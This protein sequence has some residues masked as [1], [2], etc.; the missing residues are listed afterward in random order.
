[1][2]AFWDSWN[3][4][5]AANNADAAAGMQQAQGLAAMMQQVQKQQ[6][7]QRMRDMLADPSIPPEKKR[8]GLMGL[9]T[10]PGQVA[11]MFHQQATETATNDLRTAQLTTQQRLLEESQRK[12]VED[13][14]KAEE[15]KK[16]AAAQ[17]KLQGLLAPAPSEID[18]DGSIVHRATSEA[19]AAELLRS[20][21]AKRVKLIDPM[22]VRGLQ[23]IIDPKKAIDSLLPK[24]GADYTLT[25][26]SERRNAAN[27]VVAKGQP[28]VKADRAP[29]A[30]YAWQPDGSLKFID[31]GPGDPK[32]IDAK[33]NAGVDA[34]RISDEAVD[35]A[36]RRYAF[37][38]TMPPNLGRGTQGEA[39]KVKI[40]NRAADLAKA[41]GDDGTS[42]RLN[43]VANKT[44]TQALGQLEKNKGNILAFERTALANAD[45]VIRES[46]ATERPT[47]IPAI[48]RWIQAGKKTVGGD[49]QVARLDTAVRSF[50]NEY[51]K[52][53]TTVTGGGVTSDTARR[54]IDELIKAA[55]TKEQIRGVVSL[56]K[57][58]MSNRRAGYEGE[59]KSLVDGMR[60]RNTFTPQNGAAAPPAAAP[61]A[62]PNNP[63]DYSNLWKK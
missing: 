11:N 16:I 9:M 35:Q 20:G 33:K 63:G 17:G 61:S 24:P 12:G 49:V 5:G 28:V 1:M 52:V 50:V 15:Q 44:M 18:P 60:S 6:S 31:G 57:E 48:D 26:G 34:I 21:I 47:D 30:G 45:L 38:G 53:V 62:A 55:Q 22:E 56:M 41:R 40:L 46:E 59:I 54:E 29:P 25:P 51:A 3:K 27:E 14:R 36:A 23:S 7:M 43:Q 32:V 4:Q 2:G 39:T 8:E 13:Q 19:Q 10:D 58:E 42:T 37:D